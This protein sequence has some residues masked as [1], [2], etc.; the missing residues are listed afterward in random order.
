MTLD[1]DGVF[2]GDLDLLNQQDNQSENRLPFPAAYAFWRNGAPNMKEVGGVDYFGGFAI[3]EKELPELGIQAM[4]AQ[5]KRS[6]YD[7]EGTLKVSYTSRTLTIAPI[8]QRRIWKD[9]QKNKYGTPAKGRSPIAQW[10]CLLKYDKDASNVI[11]AVLHFE[12]WQVTYFQDAL[13]AWQKSIDAHLKEIT[14]QK[15]G[16]YA[17]WLTVG[18]HGN[19]RLT[20]EVGEGD[21]TK[22]INFVSQVVSDKWDA[23]MLQARFIGKDNLKRSAELKTKAA[24]W[25]DYYKAKAAPV[26]QSENAAGPIDQLEEEYPF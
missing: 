9:K 4:P 17:F 6:E 8:T 14:P 11:P 21:N 24:Q 12:G 5:F 16:L 3:T 25:L 2:T 15:L 23:A 22:K 10:L 18:T 26:V 13:K 7:D 20:K 19:E 1:L